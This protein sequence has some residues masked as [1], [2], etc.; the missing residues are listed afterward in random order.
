VVGVLV[1]STRVGSMKV[2]A[3]VRTVHLAVRVGPVQV[4]TPWYAAMERAGFCATGMAPTE[5]VSRV[6]SE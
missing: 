6:R 3:P 5:T 1:V 2:V 4:V